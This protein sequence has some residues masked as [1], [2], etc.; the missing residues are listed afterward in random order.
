[1]VQEI[2]FADLGSSDYKQTWDFQEQLLQQ[3]MQLKLEGRNQGLGDHAPTPH[4][5]L[6]CEH[7]HV[8][9]LGK[10]GKPEHL[11]SNEQQLKNANAD[12][13]K[14][15][16]GGDITYHGPGQ[17]VGYPILN[18]D[19]FF[20]D[21]HRYMR[22]LEEV[23]IRTLK[24][25]GIEGSRIEKLT[26][27]WI[28]AGKPSARKICA[29]GVRCSRWITMHGW[30]L[31][32]NTQLDYF[33]HIVP[34]GISDKAVTSMAKELGNN[35]NIDEVKS[36]LLKHFSDVFNATIKTVEKEKLIAKEKT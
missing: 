23:I 1:M 22:F 8:F 36:V 27:V 33:N 30:A 25:Y 2:L 24:E 10:S 13:Y 16:R 20:N 32:V 28:D 11:L 29:F 21:I 35:L 34:C 26:G 4:Y 6:F 31:N 19:L 9:T 17:I 14:I 3:I 15:N 7:P 12:Y 18:L 5:L